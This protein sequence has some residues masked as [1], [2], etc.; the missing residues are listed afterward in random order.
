VVDD[1]STKQQVAYELLSNE[2]ALV[3]VADGGRAAI[4]AIAAANPQFDAV[5]M[6]VQMPDMDGYAATA[7]IRQNL[8]WFALPVIAVTANVMESD[9]LRASAA[10]MTDHV[11]KPFDLGQLVTVIL[12][13]TRGGAR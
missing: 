8:Q 10:G 6:D 5:L 12:R 4:D 13:H 11:G 1:N 7:E 3:L 2:G 9:R